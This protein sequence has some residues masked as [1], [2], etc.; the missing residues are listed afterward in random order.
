MAVGD[1]P[2][3]GLGSCEKVPPSP[4]PVVS[5]PGEGVCGDRILDG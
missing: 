5:S 2:M 1:W 3:Q 4:P